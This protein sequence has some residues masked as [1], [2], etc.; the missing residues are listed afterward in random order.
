MNPATRWLSTLMALFGRNWITM[1][2][3]GVTTV[4]AVL[5][6]AFLVPGLMAMSSTPY[7]GIFAFLIL[8]GFF[9][10]GLS[11]IPVGVY[12]DHRKKVAARRRAE[13]EAV[14]HYPT[15]NFNNPV[16]RGAA[17][18]VFFLTVVNVFIISSVSYRAVVHMDSPEF[19]GEVCHTVMQPEFTS[20]VDSPHSRV[21]CVECHIGPGAPWFVRSKLSGAGQVLAVAFNTYSHPIPTPVENLRPSQDTCEECHWPQKFTGDRVRVITNYS[22]DETNSALQ[23]VLLM[24][25]GGGASRGAGIHSWHIDP[26]KETTYI[27]TDEQRQKIAWVQV[28]EA[29]GTVTEYKAADSE[30]TPEQI[31]AAEKRRM[32]CL[33]CHNRP[34]HIFRSPARALDEAMTKG[35]IDVSLPYIKKLGVEVL[36]EVDAAGDV[37]TQIEQRV[38]A[39]YGEN[40]NEL[41]ESKRESVETAIAELAAVHKRNVFPKMD[42]TW[43]TYPNNLGH[44]EFPGCYRCHDDSH[45]SANGEVIRQDCTI[46]HAVLAWQEENPE[47]LQKLA[48]Q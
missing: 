11:I 9:V 41:L 35:R 14:S 24:H 44:E 39:Y 22:E 31:A 21:K 25:I 28:K 4:C 19:C 45:S 29:D 13:G 10:L 18:L 46:C 38:R 6:I 47:V 30:L 3:T 48:A 26:R 5:I 7:V 33:D 27:A 2:G 20:Y 15:L 23:T 32:D 43:G 42:I 40:Y 34:T 12:W 17:G 8:P 16:V 1:I 36:K 37:R